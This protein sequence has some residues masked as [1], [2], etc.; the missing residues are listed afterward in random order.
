MCDFNFNIP[1]LIFNTLIII[2]KNV[3]RDV[4]LFYFLSLVINTHV[5]NRDGHGDHTLRS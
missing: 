5:Q 3:W 1:L 2:L 4:S